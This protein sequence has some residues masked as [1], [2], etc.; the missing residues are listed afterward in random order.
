MQAER[1]AHVRLDSP[2]P[3]SPSDAPQCLA[4]LAA[5]TAGP[6]R[7][8]VPYVAPVTALGTLL[9]LLSQPVPRFIAETRRYN[10]RYQHD[11]QAG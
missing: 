1:H 2:T 9:V 11:R 3:S 7:V 10:R 4:R 8:S 6:F 5:A